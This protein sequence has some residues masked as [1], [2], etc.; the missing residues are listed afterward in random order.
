VTFNSDA[1]AVV[2]QVLSTEPGDV[3][4]VQFRMA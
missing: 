3:T 1:A 2:P 4:L